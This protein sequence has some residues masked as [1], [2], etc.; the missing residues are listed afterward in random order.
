[1]FAEFASLARFRLFLFFSFFFLVCNKDKIVS[2][3]FVRVRL[4][5]NRVFN[6]ELRIFAKF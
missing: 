3:N 6:F 2:R 5:A 4:M 1:M